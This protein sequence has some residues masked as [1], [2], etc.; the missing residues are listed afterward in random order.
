M[1]TRLKTVVTF[2]LVVVLSAGLAMAGRGGGGGH[3]GGGRWPCGGG[4]G[5]YHGGGGGGGF[6]RWRRRIPHAFFQ[7]SASEF[8]RPAS[9]F[10][11]AASRRDAQRFGRR[12]AECRGQPLGHTPGRPRHWRA[13]W[14]CQHAH[15]EQPAERR[16]SSEHRQSCEYWEPGL[17]RKPSEHRQQ[18]QYQPDEQPRPADAWRL[19]PRR[20]VSRGLARQLEQLLVLSA[21]GLVG[22]RL[23]GR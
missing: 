9:E 18:L 20:L 15:L 17:R 12:R 22:G 7:H 10:Q 3:G 16:E 4:G 11:H 2:A 14:N 23:L 6:Q 8:Q 5:G 13:A 1:N 21:G 19:E